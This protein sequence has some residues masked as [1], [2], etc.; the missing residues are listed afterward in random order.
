ME[1]KGRDLIEGIPK[2]LSVTDAEIR[3]ALGE[4]I[5]TILNAVRA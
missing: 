5:A 4:P 2:T 1:I 3:E